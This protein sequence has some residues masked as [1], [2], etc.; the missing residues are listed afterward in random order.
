MFR[1]I[2]TKVRVIWDINDREYVATV[3]LMPGTRSSGKSPER[4]LLAL[5]TAMK[6]YMEIILEE[7]NKI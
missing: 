4:A 6:E 5:A 7:G 2:N 3:G 1:A